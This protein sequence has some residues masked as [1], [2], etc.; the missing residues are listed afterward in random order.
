MSWKTKHINKIKLKRE[1]NNKYEFSWRCKKTKFRT[2]LIVNLKKKQVRFVNYNINAAN[3]KVL[4]MMQY[5]QLFAQYPGGRRE[6]NVGPGSAQIIYGSPILW[7]PTQ[8]VIMPQFCTDFDV[9]SKKKWSSVFHILISQCHFGGPS[10]AHR[11]ND[12]PPHGPL[13]SIGPGVFVHP[14]SPLL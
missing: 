8:T 11:P 1:W 14:G 5:V 4:T 6:P 2:R 10:E 12:G 3:C 9:I 7:S 13:K